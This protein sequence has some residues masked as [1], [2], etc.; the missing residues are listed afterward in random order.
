PWIH[1]PIGYAKTMNNP[2]LTRVFRTEP[3]PHLNG[4]SVDQP[5]GTTLGGSS[6]VNGL[7]HTRGHRDDFA[8]WEQYAEGWN[9]REA[10]R[11]FI[12]SESYSAGA[13]PYHGA[14]G[15]LLVSEVAEH[16]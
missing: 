9:A 13:G 7:I 10:L 15:P 4:R 5:R 3:E 1:I 11:Y 14:H 12:K 16:Q 6:A 8:A 2:A